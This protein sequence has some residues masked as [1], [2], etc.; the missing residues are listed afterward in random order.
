MEIGSVTQACHQALH[1]LFCV[2]AKWLF[3][4]F[5][6]AYLVS[7]FY[8]VERDAVGVLTRFGRVVNPGVTPGLHYKLPW[9][10]D[11]AAVVSVKEVKTLVIR[12]FGSGYRVNEGGVSYQFYKNTGLE[13]YCI[14][15]DNNIIAV[16]LVIQYT[17]DDPVKYLFGVKRPESLVERVAAHRIVRHIAQLRIDEVLTIGKKQL[18]FDLHNSIAAD[19]D[20][21]HT[22]IRVSFLEIKEIQPPG[23]VQDAF[24]RVIN[25]EVEKKKA[26]NE[27]QGY[28]NRIVPEARSAADRIIQ[29]ARA[30]KREKILAAEGETARFLSRLEGYRQN[31]AAHQEKL[32]RE[33]IRDIYPKLGQI[34]VIDAGEGQAPVV[35]PLNQ[36][37]R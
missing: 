23:K 27:A 2:Y 37:A 34:R 30:F 10:V 35:V 11:Q 29:E 25:A 15:G 3:V 19:L 4:I 28:E 18:E 7:G 13:P 6:A 21:Y 12:D 20:R 17:I 24:D 16:T 32:C 8:K 31:P 36:G 26:L 33:F 5:S 22:G 9:P 1:Q 14:T